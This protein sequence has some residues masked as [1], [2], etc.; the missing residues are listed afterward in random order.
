MRGARVRP[1]GQVAAGGGGEVSVYNTDK[2]RV[3]FIHG[4][5]IEVPVR[6][7]L[8]VELFKM[9]LAHSATILTR[10]ALIADKITT[11]A[12]GEIGLTEEK[13]SNIPKHVY[14]I[15]TQIRMSDSDDLKQA[16]ETFG[17]FTAFKARK[18]RHEPP[19]TVTS[20]LQAITAALGGFVGDNSPLR[21]R[22]KHED[23]HRS[24]CRTYLSKKE[25]YEKSQHLGD[26]L[27][28]HY[29]A[30]IVGKYLESP[31][32]RDALVENVAGVLREIEEAEELEAE[33]AE[34]RRRTML[35]G[36]PGGHRVL[37]GTLSAAQLDHA[38][39]YLGIRRLCGTI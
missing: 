13:Y 12:L 9:R 18:Y 26:M 25:E 30:E 22:R 31:S 20:T 8:E 2:I 27:L 16:L 35:D 34:E 32:N 10:G 14:D 37:K 15:G 5:D 33:E 11:L 21:M 6:R 1:G 19:Y 17:A 4:M 36:L 24:F 3:D 28:T 39:L 38:I 29:F 23:R 7:I